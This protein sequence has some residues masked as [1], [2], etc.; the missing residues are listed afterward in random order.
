M[1][2]QERHADIE[3]GLSTRR[4]GYRPKQRDEIAKNMSA[5]RSTE[6]KT[7]AA[8]RRALHALGLR[9]RKYTTDLP[10]KPD[11]VFRREMVA[12]F[13]DGDYWHARVFREGGQAALRASIRNPN[14]D[15]WLKKFLRN[16]ARDA[17]VNAELEGR[18]W[19]VLRY[20]ESD[21]KRNL[22]P[23]ANRIARFVRQRR[24]TARTL[25]TAF[26]TSRLAGIGLN[27][28]TLSRC[29]KKK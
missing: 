24:K 8:L 23:T 6:N 27:H 2:S 20:W 3:S 16:A 18:G 17:A 1:D 19:L 13:V 26:C 28:L 12:V 9:Y 7:E 21:V 22:G 25:K 15:Y 29:T 5:I 10:G 4:R 14:V 11:I